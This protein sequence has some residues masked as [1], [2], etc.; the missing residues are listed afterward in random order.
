MKLASRFG[1]ESS[2]V[3]TIPLGRPESGRPN[4]PKQFPQLSWIEN[5]LGGLPAARALGK[6]EGVRPMSCPLELTL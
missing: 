5:P 1:W 4:L 6:A 2:F 3:S